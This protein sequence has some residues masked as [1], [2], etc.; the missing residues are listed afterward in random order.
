[1]IT[2]RFIKRE[3]FGDY[4]RPAKFC[5]KNKLYGFEKASHEII[6]IEGID[7]NW[8][9]YNSDRYCMAFPTKD[10]DHVLLFE[11]DFQARLPLSH[12]GE[13]YRLTDFKKAK[14]PIN[15]YTG[16]VS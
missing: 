11:R 8:W 7:Y 14:R 15:P 4:I 3:N 12:N 10:I 2:V 16:K 5:L 9:I 13:N 6:I 1:M